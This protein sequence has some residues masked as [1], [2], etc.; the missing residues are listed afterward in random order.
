MLLTGWRYLESVRFNRIVRDLASEVIIAQPLTFLNRSNLNFAEDD[1]IL[2][3]YSRNI[4]AADI[5]TDDAEA[6][7]VDTGSFRTFSNVI[8]N[9]KIGVS[10][11]QS[12]I[13]RLA[14]MKRGAILRGD[15]GIVTNWELGMSDTVVQSNRIR[16]NA[17][18]CGVMLDSVI[19]DRL[20]VKVTGTFGMPSD[21]KVTLAG[22]RTW[23]NPTTALPV[24]DVQDIL[25]YALLTYG[26]RFNRLDM[27]RSTFNKMIATTQFQNM[28]RFLATTAGSAAAAS[29][30]NLGNLPLMIGVAK[31]LLGVD[32]INIEDNYYDVRNSDGTKTRLRYF[33]VNLVL[34]SNTAD[35]KADTGWDFANGIVTESIVANLMQQVPTA[36]AGEQQGP[37]AYYT[38]PA[39]LNPPH[40]EAWCVTRGFGRRIRET[41][42]AKLTAGAWTT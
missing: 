27:S 6:V 13:N 26:E 12:M 38:G 4:F 36:L 40:I 35:D 30:L 18:M 25:N 29:L 8:P 23:D 32:I 19:Y 22:G 16:M 11:R 1:E 5:I 21:L 28:A 24:T 3:V 42:T 17:I 15:A 2:G 41:C 33:P 37:Y 14:R 10:I 31:A 34:F 20:G 39:D 7:I 9:I